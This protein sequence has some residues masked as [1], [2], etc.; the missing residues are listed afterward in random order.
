M[1]AFA[2][3]C[4]LAF[5]RTFII[6]FVLLFAGQLLSGQDTYDINTNGLSEYWDPDTTELFLVFRKKFWDARKINHLYEATH[7]VLLVRLISDDR[8]IS[9]LEKKGKKKAA[10]KIRKK[11]E[12]LNQD[13]VNAF[14]DH[15]EHEVYFYHSHD[16]EELLNNMDLSK[17]MIN[18]TDPAE[19]VIIENMAYVL[20]YE[21][22]PGSTTKKFN[23][24]IWN[25]KTVSRLPITYMS[26]ESLL[27]SK[28]DIYETISNFCADV[29]LSKEK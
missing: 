14:N 22:P 29:N 7:N 1:H 23:L 6:I 26:Y 10:E 16:A 18:T 8:R 17:L 28:K 4:K 9:I 19:G 11:T 24:N 5:M 20:L 27:S 2:D 12:K 13:I 3:T 25:K 21:A 15:Y